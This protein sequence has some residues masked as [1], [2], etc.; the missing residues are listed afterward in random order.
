MNVY[1][2][3]INDHIGEKYSTKSDSDKFRGKMTFY[4]ILFI[5]F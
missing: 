3:D 4:T 5:S 2:R 1:I